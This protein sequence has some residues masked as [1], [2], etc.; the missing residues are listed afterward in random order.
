M[1]AVKLAIDF[2]SAY[3]NI[4]MLG[5]GLVLSEPTV[6]AVSQDEKSEIKAIGLEAKKLIGKTAKNTKIV[7]PVFEGEIVNEKIAIATLG[8]FLDKIG[9]RGK[10]G[11]CHAV[12][13]VPCGVTPEMMEKFSIVAKKSGITKAYFVE[14]P[15]LSALGQRIPLN[16]S[17]P[18]FIVE[19]GGGITN[20][21]AVSL[22]GVIAGISVNFG[23]NKIS[24]D[25]IDYVAETY[26][27]QIGLLTAER[28]KKE[29][30][31]LAKN[32]GL[33]TVV[34]GRDVKTGTPRSIS[35][36]AKDIIEPV[37]L[38]FDK[39]VD[40][41]LNVLKKLPPEVSAEIRHAGIY[42]SGEVASVYGLSDYY[43]EKFGMKINVAEHPLMSVALG[44]G[45]AVG[46]IDLLKK[47]S[48]NLR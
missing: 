43:G 24:T 5:G 26:G 25:I 23:S 41:A 19:M 20:I 11:G 12:F 28:L 37:S 4:Y 34:N 35:L 21:A 1:A 31:S 8:A 22:D 15:I 14:T 16:D 18:C 13:S 40:L 7:F 46:D 36:K 29:I 44:G 33:T 42:V 38:Y 17:S 45:V 10:L 2:G 27:L 9:A 32:D 6:V 30:A 39:I 3:T 48:I 47:I